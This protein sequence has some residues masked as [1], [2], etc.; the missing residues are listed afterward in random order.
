MEDGPHIHLEMLPRHERSGASDLRRL[1]GEQQR[2]SGGFAGA[3]LDVQLDGGYAYVLIG[4]SPQSPW[5]TDG[6]GAERGADPM[7]PSRTRQ[8]TRV[9]PL[10]TVGPE[11][12]APLTLGELFLA[13]PRNPPTRDVLIFVPR[14]A[15]DL[16][17]PHPEPAQLST[18]R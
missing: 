7:I 14:I 18:V 11:A 2:A 5:P 1:L 17:A 16:F 12:V 15:A 4:E 13:G 10:E 6:G 9:G 3:V 8:S